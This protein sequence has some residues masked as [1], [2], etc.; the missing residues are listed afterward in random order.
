[1]AA[2]LGASTAMVARVGNDTFGHDTIKN[3]KDN[4]VNVSGLSNGRCHE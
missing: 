2:R 4:H 1:M 3:F